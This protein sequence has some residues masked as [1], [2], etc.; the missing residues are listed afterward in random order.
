M[1]I[2]YTAA[3]HLIFDVPQ[4]VW[5]GESPEIMQVSRFA[6]QEMMAIQV[7]D[8]EPG[9]FE[10]T[11]MGLTTSGFLTM[12]EAKSNAPA[13]AKKCLSRLVEMITD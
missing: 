1:D 6:G 11:F 10:L 4:Q 5:H 13:F 12:E 9:I 8:D 3:G 7:S 2:K